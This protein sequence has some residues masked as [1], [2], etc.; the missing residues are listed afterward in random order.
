MVPASNLFNTGYFR[1]DSY[2]DLYWLYI[3]EVKIRIEHGEIPTPFLPIPI[4]SH[5]RRGRRPPGVSDREC[6]CVASSRAFIHYRDPR[7]CLLCSDY[8]V[9]R[10]YARLHG[11]MVQASRWT[12]LLSISDGQV[13]SYRDTA[14][15]RNKPPASFDAR[16]FARPALS[17][18][19]ATVW[20]LPDPDFMNCSRF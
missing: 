3:Q 10:I 4:A 19:C 9:K 1:E 17:L 7:E 14:I 20:S 18:R 2:G 6:C 15:T 16:T 5:L 8:W 11:A 13:R 12:E